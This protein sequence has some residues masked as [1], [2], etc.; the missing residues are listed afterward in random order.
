[1]IDDGQNSIHKQKQG[2]RAV[3]VVLPELFCL[4]PSPCLLLRS[5]YGTYTR[6]LYL[7]SS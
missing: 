4:S 2:A 6:R 7:I 5:Y 1:M 3:Q